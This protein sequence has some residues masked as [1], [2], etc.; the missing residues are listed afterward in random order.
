M[1]SI[2]CVRLSARHTVDLFTLA[3]QAADL[4][5]QDALRD[6]CE[7]VTIARIVPALARLRALRFLPTKSPLTIPYF[8]SAELQKEVRKALVDPIL[9]SD[10]SSI[11]RPWPSTWKSRRRKGI[12]VVVDLVDVDSDKWRQYSSFAPFPYS[13][14]YRREANRLG[15]YERAVCE[16]ASS[17][18]VTTDREAQLVREICPTA[19]RPCDPEWR[20]SGVFQSRRP[21]GQRCAPDRQ[22]HGRHELLSE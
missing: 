13:S 14:V 11:A 21:A 3:D 22:L 8:Y 16:Q 10:L 1:L 18:V 7:T 12:P 5:H 6:Y 2:N 9:R 20:G 19:R 4:E 15:E 17:V